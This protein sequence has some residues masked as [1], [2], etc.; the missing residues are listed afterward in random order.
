MSYIKMF[1]KYICQ[2]LYKTSKSAFYKF[3]NKKS[4]IYIKTLL[5]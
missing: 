4:K 1:N 3:C 2:I 5:T